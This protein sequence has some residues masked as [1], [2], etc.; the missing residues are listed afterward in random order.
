MKISRSGTSA[1]HG[2]SSIELNTPAF[3]WR[4]SDSR[5]AIKQLNVKDFST[6]SHHDYTIFL[7]LPEL[8]SLFQCLSEAIQTEPVVFE[9]GLESSLKA[10]IRI[11]AAVAGL[12]T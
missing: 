7:S 5:L 11:Q 1:D 9:K 12:K 6:G 2:V 3:T 4:K 10:L 8:V